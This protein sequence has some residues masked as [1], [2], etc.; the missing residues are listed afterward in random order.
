MMTTHPCP[1]CRKPMRSDASALAALGIP[2]SAWKCDP[3]FEA[4]R[5]D[6]DRAF[7]ELKATMIN[8]GHP[9]KPTKVIA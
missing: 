3:C 6:F 4:E 7:N 1:R 2:L 8:R 9:W 5:A